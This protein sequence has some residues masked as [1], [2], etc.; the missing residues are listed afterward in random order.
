MGSAHTSCA[1]FVAIYREGAAPLKFYGESEVCSMENM[2]L[3]W[4]YQLADQEL[5]SFQRKLKDTPTRK[6]LLK[7]QSII[8]N[9]Q[10][11]VAEME[12][13]AR[14][15]QNRISE[16]HQQNKA[17]SEDIQDMDQ[18]LGYFSE[19]EDDEL[20]QKEIETLLKSS[21]RAY[22]TVVSIK[23]QISQI[24]T[25]LEQADKAIIELF[26]KMKAAKKEYDVLK[27]EYNAEISTGSGEVEALKKKL[28][29]AEAQVE[30]G[31]IAEYKRVKGFRQNPV[32]ALQDN[33]CSGCR[34]QLPSGVAAKV[35]GSKEPVECE[36]CGR[37]LVIL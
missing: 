33:R 12:N 35:T 4:E 1:D 8:K 5:E 20:D 31:I 18:D 27:V 16:L 2:N 24:K 28:A 26:T 10:S 32:A 17:L 7:L 25:E 6:K 21:E 13:A 11:K 34:M 29:T 22:E 30:P 3:L 9:G 36:N 19:C 14:V 37:V 23:K 15:K